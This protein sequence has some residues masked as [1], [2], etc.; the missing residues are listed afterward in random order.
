MYEYSYKI[1]GPAMEEKLV[2]RELRHL[3]FSINIFL[4]S[5]LVLLGFYTCQL[6][7]IAF[8]TTNAFHPTI[9][10]DEEVEYSP[11]R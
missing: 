1:K 8:L 3:C 4:V 9:Q 5:T 7:L 2:G 11:G 6:L 10:V